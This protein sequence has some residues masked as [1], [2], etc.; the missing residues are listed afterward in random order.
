[1]GQ[2]VSSLVSM[3]SDSKGLDALA[4]LVIALLLQKANESKEKEKA[5]PW[6]MLAGMALMGMMQQQGQVSLF[7]EMSV[8]GAN[9][10]AFQSTVAAASGGSLNMQG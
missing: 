10:A 9:G 2:H 8:S 4:S 6:A 1:M 5:D 7:Q 3:T